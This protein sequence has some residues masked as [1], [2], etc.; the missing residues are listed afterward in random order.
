[1]HLC[2]ILKKSD[3]GLNE[4]STLLET[5]GFRDIKIKAFQKEVQFLEFPSE[6]PFYANPKGSNIIVSC[7]HSSQLVYN[8]PTR[9]YLKV[10]TALALEPL[11]LAG[12]GLGKIC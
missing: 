3:I 12:Q 11:L 10:F 8:C 1:M 2:V 6:P 7:L 5:V 9:L 4:L